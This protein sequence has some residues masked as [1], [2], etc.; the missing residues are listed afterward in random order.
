VGVSRRTKF[1]IVFTF[2]HERRRD[3]ETGENP[4]SLGID[5]PDL[6]LYTEEK[7]RAALL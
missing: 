1:H 5:D 4:C 6:I 7:Q 2:F 3:L